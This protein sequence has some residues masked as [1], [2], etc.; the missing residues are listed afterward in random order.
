VAIL[1]SWALAFIPIVVLATIFWKPALFDGKTIIHGDSLTDGLSMLSMQARSFRHLGQLLWADGVYGGHPIFAEGQGAFASPL[2]ILLAWVVAPLTG[3]IAAMNIGHWLMMLL[4]GAGV[5]GLC[6]CLG[7]GLAASAFASLAVV[8]SP[9]WVGLAQN[10]TIQGAL[11]W[12]PWAFWALEAWLKRPGVRQSVLLGAAV[13]IIILSGYPQAF[14]GATVYMAATLLAVPF[15]TDARRAWA[16][17]WRTRLAMGALAVLVC[18]GLSAV[19]WMPL[20]ELTGL[21]HRSAGIGMLVRVPHIDYIRGLLYTWPRLPDGRDYFPGLGSLLVAL[22]AALAL[23]LPTPARIKGHMVAAYV[24]MQL[25]IEEASPL[26]R[27]VYHHD[28]L[29]GLRYFRTVHLYIDIA[30]IGFAV[31]AAAAIDSLGRLPVASRQVLRAAWPRLA[32]GLLIIAL[33]AVAFALVRVPDLRWMNYGIPLAALLGGCVFIF[34]GRTQFVPLLML[35]LLSAECMNLRLHL[36]HFHDPSV[37]A[38]P[39]SSSA[40]LGAERQ[41]DGK[42]FDIS[43]AGTYGFTDPRTPAVVDQARRMMA[44]NSAMTNTLWGLR[45]LEGALALPMR[46]QKE[47]VGRIRD[48]LNGKVSTPAGARLMDL[49]A[50]RFIS[51]AQPVNV[52]GSTL[53]WSDPA[54]SIYFMENGAAR[55]RFQLYAHHVTVG[56]PDEA[57]ATI[58]ALRTPTLVIENPPDGSQLEQ[59]D[60]PTVDDD[61]PGQF[62]VLKAKSTEYR[63]DVTANRAAWFFVADANYPG[64]RATLD[65]KPAPL[66]SA[67]LLGK[68]VAIPQGHHR[69]EIAFRSSTFIAGLSISAMSLIA[70]LFALWNGKRLALHSP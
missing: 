2:T 33:A 20:V 39:A 5:I 38:E 70:A 64:W 54:L 62:T 27:L 1:R 57:L 56:S 43:E 12:V 14:H 7:F 40:I 58:A 61:S 53:F 6:R 41:E 8:F 35:A 17:E 49:L 51:A 24:L 60:D 31:L 50:V 18:A 25:G 10:M 13:A 22:L 66:F 46:R 48:E 34:A 23:A 11:T 32:A 9:I 69:L 19:Q 52:P 55:P 37:L 16:A 26:F 42:L 36:F 45:S 68:A 59:A 63:V 47:A 29:P 28:L 30:V 67:Q 4:T 44:A 21:S 15:D 3:I 65:G